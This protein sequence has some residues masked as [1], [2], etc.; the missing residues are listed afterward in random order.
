MPL[1]MEYAGS[2]ALHIE[3]AFCVRAQMCVGLAFWSSGNNWFGFGVSW[4]PCLSDITGV[5]REIP[6][7]DQDP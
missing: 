1:W 3:P 6:S 4:L 7:E 5:P 2:I